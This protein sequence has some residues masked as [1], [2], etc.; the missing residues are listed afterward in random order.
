M[1]ELMDPLAARSRYDRLIKPDRVH[2]SLYT[3]PEIFA[4]ELAQDLVPHLGLR[5]SRERGRPAGRLRAQ[6]ARPAGRDHDPGSGRRGAPAA[7]PVR[8]PRQPGLRRRPGQLQ[9][10]PLPLPRL[11]LPEH[12]RA[13]RLPVLPGLRRQRNRTRPGAGRG[14]AGRLLPGLRVRQLRGRR[15]RA[16]PSTSGRRRASST[17]W[18]GSPPRGGWSSPPAGSSTGPRPTGSCWPRTRPTGTTRSSS[19]APSSASPA[20]RSARCTAISP[21]R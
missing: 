19:T 3:S 8:A 4:E 2:G 1:T 21:L 16:W 11:D 13:D 20:A 5:R 14:A 18:P 9:L 17:G 10:V 7:E 12:R 6:E 15:A